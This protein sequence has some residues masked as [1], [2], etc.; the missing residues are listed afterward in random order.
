[1]KSS[2]AAFHAHLANALQSIGFISSLADPDVWYRAAIKPNGEKYYEYLLTYVDDILLLL[3]DPNI[4][5]KQLT[6]I[7]RFKEPPGKPKKYLGADVFEF[8][9]PNDPNKKRRWGMS[10]E[11]YVKEA[12]RMVKVELAKNDRTLPKRS[13]S[14]FTSGYHPE[15]DFTALLSHERANYYQQ[16]IGMFWP[17]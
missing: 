17:I 11:Q 5:F 8:Y 13:T 12:V 14:P 4:A 2:G 6:E 15:L 10:S 16:L 3:C 9:F 7:Y 1:M